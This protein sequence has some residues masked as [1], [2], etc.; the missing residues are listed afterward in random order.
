ME[1]DVKVF[2]DCGEELKYVETRYTDNGVEIIVKQC[3]NCLEIEG[4]KA[5]K[6]GHDNG[7][8]EAGG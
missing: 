2:C 3:E 8:D 7:Y 5:Y 6:R 1:I 4:T